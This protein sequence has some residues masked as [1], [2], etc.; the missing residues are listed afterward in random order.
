MLPTCSLLLI[1]PSH[2]VIIPLAL[3]WRRGW[4][5][6]ILLRRLL[7]KIFI[8]LKR[9]FGKLRDKLLLYLFMHLSINLT[10]L[11][12]EAIVLIFKLDFGRL[13]DMPEV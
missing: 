12:V 2:S 3:T 8:L 5:F 9:L 11:Q 6:G 1:L 4:A 10:W 7:G 13:N